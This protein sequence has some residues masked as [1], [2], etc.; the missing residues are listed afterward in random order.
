MK[1]AA[2]F[3]LVFVTAPDLKTARALSKAALKAKLIACANLIPKTESHYWWRGEIESGAEVLLVLKTQKT[4]LAAL[5][6]LILA[7]HPYDTPEILVLPV[8]AGNKKYLGWLA[9]NCR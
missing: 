9:E 3:A 8:G 1:S 2:T 6:K 5:E 7:R 4:K